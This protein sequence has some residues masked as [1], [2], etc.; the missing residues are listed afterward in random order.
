MSD[1]SGSNTQSFQE[2]RRRE[3]TV[4]VVTLLY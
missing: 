3:E 1:V 2:E 4:M